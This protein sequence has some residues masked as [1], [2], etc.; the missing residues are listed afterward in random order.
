MVKLTEL[1]TAAEDASDPSSALV[2]AAQP[3][4]RE[5]IAGRNA[6]LTTTERRMVLESF[7][8][9]MIGPFAHTLD[10]GSG[11]TRTARWRCK[12][13]PSHDEVWISYRGIDAARRTRPRAHPHS[14]K[15]PSPPRPGVRPL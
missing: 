13:E 6:L 10:E 14:T 8:M 9:H 3:M 15:G 5:T 2:V 11:R 4:A 12:R 7:A 1:V